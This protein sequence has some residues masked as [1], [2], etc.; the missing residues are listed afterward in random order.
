[1]M[2]FALSGMNVTDLVQVDRP[3]LQILVIQGRT[4]EIIGN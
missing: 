4:K 1:V 2:C 3:G